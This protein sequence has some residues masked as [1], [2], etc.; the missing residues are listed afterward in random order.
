[1][2]SFVP[3]NDLV[4]RNPCF[5][6]SPATISVRCQSADAS[7]TTAQSRILRL[8]LPTC[9]IQTCVKFDSFPIGGN[10]AIVVSQVAP[11]SESAAVGLRPG[12]QLLALSDPIQPDLT[13]SLSGSASLRYVRDAVRMRRADYILLEVT[14]EPVAQGNYDATDAQDSNTDSNS[15]Q[16][17]RYNGSNT[18]NYDFLSAIASSIE[19]D[20]EGL[21]S[22]RRSRTIGERLQKQYEE[23]SIKPATT[24][25]ERRISRRKDY[26]TQVTKRN[27]VPFFAWLLAAFLLPALCILAVA[28]SSGYLEALSQQWSHF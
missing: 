12:M 14:R 6:S 13:W 10:R 20:E 9:D 7:Q 21:E 24:A 3:R 26:M 19:S 1:M 27:D 23:S 15:D 25:L 22:Q 4:P 28:A 11:G 18:D 17:E 5:T 8:E 16:N 2:T